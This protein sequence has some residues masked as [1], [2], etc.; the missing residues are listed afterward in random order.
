MIICTRSVDVKAK[1]AFGKQEVAVMGDVEAVFQKFALDPRLSSPEIKGFIVG[2]VDLKNNRMRD[3]F[4]A[5]AANKHPDVV[6]VYCARNAKDN[7]L[8]GNGIDSVLVNPKPDDLAN[9]IQNVVANQEGQRDLGDFFGKKERIQPGFNPTYDD[10]EDLTGMGDMSLT[11]G[12]DRAPAQE[13]TF[14]PTMPDFTPATE[15]TF[16]PEAPVDFNPGFSFGE[17]PQADELPLNYGVVQPEPE[18]MQ[19]ERANSELVNRVRECRTVSDVEIVAK[20]ITAA[21]VVKDVLKNNQQYA[22]IEERLK[23]VTEKIHAIFADKTIPTMEEKLERIQAILVDKDYLQSKNNTIIEQRVEEIIKT[24]TGQTVGLI[25]NRLRE[26]DDA[27]KG[28][29]PVTANIDYACLAGIADE[30]ANLL[31]EITNLKQNIEKVYASVDKLAAGTADLMAGK[32]ADMTGNAYLDMQLQ[33]RQSSIVS[34]DSIDAMIHVLETADTASQEFID[35]KRNLTIMYKKLDKLIEVDKESIAALAQV[36]EYMRVNKMED[37]VVAETLIKRAL[38]IFIGA[39]GSGKTVMPYIIS[40]RKSRQNANVLYIDLTGSCKLEDYGEMYITLDDWL[41]NRHNKDFC[42]VVGKPVDSDTAYQDLM[43]AIVKAADYYQSINVVLTPEQTEL[44]NVIGPSAKVVNY[45]M[46]T[47]RAELDFYSKF[48]TDTTFENVAR[49]VILN[50]CGVPTRPIIERLG[51]LNTVDVQVSK[52]PYI[53]SL[54]ECSLTGTKPYDLSAV[55]E[56]FT[57]V[58]DAC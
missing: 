8:V 37:A 16:T 38:R 19:E 17:E 14:A 42:V 55:T 49:R 57:E 39:E 52:I 56:G 13:P 20:Q 23:A 41:M 11:L 43:F 35:A 54:I 15:S 34:G 2:G 12:Y 29:R 25:N 45:I 36:I 26:L 24:I 32:A 18:P 4:L 7:I 10:S 30:R 47:S 31:L 28:N 51:L 48:L 6:I 46:G 21:E 9:C 50:K 22:L 58:F 44:L 33:M 3:A 27:I 1:N 53:P 40:K 5:A